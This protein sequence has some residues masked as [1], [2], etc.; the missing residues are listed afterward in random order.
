MHLESLEEHVRLMAHTLAQALELRTIQVIS[1]NGVVIRVRALLNNNT[2]TLTRRQTTDIGKTLLSNDNIEIML[3]LIDVGSERND[4]ADTG[5][6]G[7]ARPG[8]RGVHN[9]VL[10]VTQE[11]G[12]TTE[13]VQHAGAHDT[14]G[15]GVSVDVHF[16]GG[17]HSDTPETTDDLGAVGDL[18][19]TEE[20]LVGVLLPVIVEA[21]ETVGGETDG[22]SGG[23]VQVSAVEEV[24]EGVLQNLS[25][26]LEVLEV[27]AALGETSDDGVGDVTNAGLDR[28]EV[29]GKATVVNLVLEELNQ[30]G[31]DGLGA[32]IFRGV[33]LSLVGVGGLHD[34][35][36]LLG[37][38]GDERLSDA[39]L[40]C[41][42]KVWLA[43]RRQIGADDIVQAL[44]RRHGGVKLNNDLIGHLNQLRRGADRGTG[45]NTTAFCDGGSLDNGD[46]DLVGWPVLC[47]VALREALAADRDRQVC[48]RE[49]PSRS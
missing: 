8:R 19:G 42:D 48:P 36:D 39:V 21:L 45:N 22:S 28:K 24:E 32:L 29:L 9:G 26:D 1:E 10:G 11:V 7:L 12:G 23:E 3:G 30:V 34:G 27:G 15:V 25:P 16:D 4:T 35:D 5:G 49:M 13:T 44:E 37:V 18:L 6:I 20:E 40:R 47:V 38:N 2:G 43:A 31:G 14:G 46:V 17:V 33:W 41:H